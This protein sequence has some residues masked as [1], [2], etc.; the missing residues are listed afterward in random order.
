VAVPD[1][2]FGERVCA[3]V[4]LR[5]GSLSLAELTAFLAGRGVSK[6]YF[7]EYLVVLDELPQSMGGKIAKRELTARLPD[8]LGEAR[9]L[10]E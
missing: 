4:S 5:G 7:P 3:V 1:E 8:L 10:S 6:E 2:V 9:Q